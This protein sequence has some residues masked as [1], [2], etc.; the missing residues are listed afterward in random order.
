VATKTPS[1]DSIFCSA[2][3]IASK[4]ERTA[5]LAR[6][7]GDDADLRQHVDKLV[8]AHFRAGNFLEKPATGLPSPSGG[9]GSAAKLPSPPWGRG[10]G[11]EGVVPT[12]D[13]PPINEVAGTRIGPYKLLEQIGEGGMGT[14]WMADQQEPVRRIVALK[15]IKAG[16]DSAQVIARFEAERQALALMDHPNIAKVLDAGTVGHVSNVPGGKGH[17][18]NVPHGGRPYFVMELV[19]GT[20]ITK[21]CDEHR[22]TPRQR[23]ELFVPVC[24]AIQHAHQKGIIHRDVKPSNVLVAPYDGK[25]V[26]K[27]IDFGVAKAT[28][29][30]LTERTLFTGFGAVVGTL[31]YMSPEQAELNNQD[32]DTRSDIYSLGVLLYELLTGTTPLT[33]ERLKQAPFTE[34]L[35]IIREEEPPTPSTRLSSSDTLPAIAAAR[36]TEPV[37]LTK[38]VRGELD[39]IVMKALDKDRTRR[40]ETASAL[41]ADLQRYLNDELV[42]ARPP[43]PLYKFGKL[44]RRHKRVFAMAGFATL[45]LLVALAV[46]G[47]SYAQVQH[48]QQQ[49]S[50]ALQRERE[51]TNGLTAA[52][53][54]ERL[55]RAKERV[56]SYYQRIALADREWSA[57]NLGRMEQL[58]ADCPEDLRGWEWRYLKGLRRQALSPLRHEAAVLCAAI[59]HDG[60]RI[61]SGS[62]DGVIKLWDASSGQELYSFRAHASHVRSVVFSPDGLR[63]ASGSFDRTVKVW[64]VRADQLLP[65]WEKSTSEKVLSVAFSPDGQSLASG[66]GDGRDGSEELKLWD[67]AAGE[68]IWARQ[69]PNRGIWK[70]AFHPDGH[71]LAWKTQDGYVTVWDLETRRERLSL[72]PCE[73]TGLL[74]FSP[75]G[76]LLAFTESG[77]RRDGGEVTIWDWQTGR[78]LSTLRGHIGPIY[79]LAFSP[80][81]RR[82]ATGSMDQTIKIWDAATGE[83]ALTLRDHGGGVM[84]VVFS[85]N[86]HRLVSTGMDQRVRVWDARPWQ[87]GEGQEFLTLRGHA[88]GVTSVAFHPHGGLLASGS[89]DGTVKLWDTM[90]WKEHFTLQVGTDIVNTIAFSPDGKCLATGDQKK[91]VKLWDIDPKRARRPV[92]DWQGPHPDGI[93]SVA[94][95]PDS[96]LLATAGWGGI[97]R[98]WDMATGE[99]RQELKGHD[100]LISSVAFSPEGHLASASNDTTVRVWNVAAGLEIARLE[101]YHKGPVTSLAFSRDGN[102]LAS[103]SED[104]TVRVWEKGGDAK[105]W[106]LLKRLSHPGGGVLSVAI[107]PLKNV[108]LAWSAMDGTVT[109]WD[110][111]ADEIHVLR[112][113]TSWVES[114]AFSPEGEYIASGSRDGTV[115]IWKTPR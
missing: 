93:L 81:G 34:M 100:W 73:G 42:E 13:E 71:F 38:L 51:A 20:P 59:S 7:C 87:D 25:P 103:A 91:R 27:V 94:F 63:L 90:T 8:A 46:F 28:G 109:V 49:T 2:I 5:Y 107:S 4:E 12:V 31:E 115:K 76:R 36:Q 19:K 33:K 26:V 29:R 112:G 111:T 18:E 14:V 74:A 78:Q 84:S 113:H 54:R 30:R 57:N 70:L 80:D 66:G 45:V 98:V 105:T 77:R 95:S 85:P 65:V 72:G 82:L 41:A 79:A 68:I 3:E 61:A 48:E 50:D 114:V 1:L 104:R 75:D 10:V 39:W 55:L 64:N 69:G 22:L 58:L 96:K 37:K 40:F 6:V 44:V 15:V 106:K 32:I 60:K 35:R 92:L 16:M 11:G 101:R 97:V 86:G 52:F 99:E 17:V 43:S 24:Q 23:L 56:N 9:E 67:A 53:E 21:Y 89:A 102:L 108:R 88:R 47:V 62:Q 110:Q 83:A